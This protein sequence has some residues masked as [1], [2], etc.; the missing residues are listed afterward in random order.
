MKNLGGELLCVLVRFTPKCPTW[1]VLVFDTKI[2]GLSD[3]FVESG[4]VT[5][6]S[7]AGVMNGKHYN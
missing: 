2:A 1:H 5:S 7:L 4:L 6:D 3:I